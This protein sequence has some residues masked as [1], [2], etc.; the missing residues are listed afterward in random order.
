MRNLRINK[1]PRPRNTE[2]SNDSTNIPLLIRRVPL[3]DDNDFLGKVLPQ[4]LVAGVFQ[5]RE[6]LGGDERA[7]QAC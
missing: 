3:A 4:E 7:K 2:Q 1:L 5:E 6:E